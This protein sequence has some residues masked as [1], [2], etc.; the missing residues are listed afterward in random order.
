M[1]LNNL[2]S[3]GLNLNAVSL[4]LYRL[5]GPGLPCCAAFSSHLCKAFTLKCIC[6]FAILS[7]STL[8]SIF[9][10]TCWPLENITFTVRARGRNRSV[11][12]L[13]ISTI[14]TYAHTKIA[15]HST[16]VG[17]ALARPN[18]DNCYVYQHSL[19]KST[20]SIM[21]AVQ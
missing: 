11:K 1:V 16:S 15:I 2:P 17:L 19:S 10:S 9:S 3:V 7:P 13:R 5:V 18:N 21:T 14:R 4:G 6:A 20:V 8:R 12:D